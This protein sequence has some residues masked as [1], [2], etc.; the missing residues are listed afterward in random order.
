MVTK[1]EILDLAKPKK[2]KF[3]M[4]IAF[5]VEYE[6]E[7]DLY[8]TMDPEQMAKQDTEAACSNP[9]VAL[10]AFVRYPGAKFRAKVTPVQTAGEKAGL[11]V[12]RPLKATIIS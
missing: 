11:T 8:E 4:V 6:A 2:Q 3:R 12:E 7:V 10:Q 5:Q 1:D 9:Y